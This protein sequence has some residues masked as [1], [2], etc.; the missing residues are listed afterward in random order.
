MTLDGLRNLMLDDL[1]K[2]LERLAQEKRDDVLAEVV[3][4]VIGR[5]V[6]VTADAYLA[7]CERQAGRADR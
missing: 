2:H 3:R 5:G 4:L 7:E 6:E 1:G